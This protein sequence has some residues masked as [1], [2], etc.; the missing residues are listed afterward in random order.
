MSD[1]YSKKVLKE[2][3]DMENGFFLIENKNGNAI[4]KVTPAGKLGTKVEAIQVITRVQIFGVEEYDEREIRKIVKNADG[5]EHIIGKWTGGEPENSRAEILIE[6]NNMEASITL[7]PPKHGGFML[8]ENGIRQSLET[9]GIR[10]GII[11]EIITEL[12]NEPEYHRPYTIAEGLP[13]LAGGDG[14]IELVFDSSNTP[15]LEAD[16]RGRVDFREIN[17]IKSIQAG[18]VLAKRTN[19]RPGKNGINVYGDEIPFLP[20][21][22]LEWKLGSNVQLSN[23]GKEAIATITGRPV[24]DRTGILRVDEVVHLENVDFSTGNVDFPGTI[25]VEEKIADGFKLTTQ[26]SLIIKSQLEKCSYKQKV[27]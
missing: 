1:E 6:S 8:D 3:E 4:L 17:V 25:I 10:Y 15:N 16:A 21:R 12:A 13:P 9:A 14:E 26:G 2:L 27:M 24:L 20:G 11:D 7:F 18:K 22:E 5:K 23:D 19:P